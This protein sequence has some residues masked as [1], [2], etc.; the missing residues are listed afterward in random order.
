MISRDQTIYSMRTRLALRASMIA[1][2]GAALIAGAPA[3]AQDQ[4][5]PAPDA[6]TQAAE[7][8]AAHPAAA[9]EE[10]DPAD[11]GCRDGVQE[12]RAAARSQV[13]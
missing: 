7:E 6:A 5:A 10:A 1:L 3:F 13:D 4:A 8:R 11:H 12:D 2:G 9:A